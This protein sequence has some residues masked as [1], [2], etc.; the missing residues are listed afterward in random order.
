M[1][2]SSQI[3]AASAS[4]KMDLQARL[5]LLAGSDMFSGLPQAALMRLAVSMTARDFSRG[6]AVFRK[7]DEAAAMFAV[8]AGQIRIAV[9]CADGRGHVL[10]TLQ[11]GAFFGEIG[12]LDGQRRTADAVA[13]TKCRVLLLDRRQVI[14]V[15][16]QQPGFA[17]KVM[18]ILC[19]RLRVTSGRVEDLVFQTLSTRLATVLLDLIKGSRTGSVDMTQVELSELTG[20]TRESVNKKLRC[21]QDSGVVKLQPG[22]IMVVDPVAMRRLAG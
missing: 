10:R 20:V 2:I 8:F 4:E 6:A 15:I 11:P 18:A 5:R 1:Y 17:L 14:Q 19:E 21:W 12:V 13:V 9:G 16:E 22:R 3:S 7:G